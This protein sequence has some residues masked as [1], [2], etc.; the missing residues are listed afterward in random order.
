[1]KRTIE[2]LCLAILS[3]MPVQVTEQAKPTVAIIGTG[4]MG[5]SLGPKIAERGYP[6]VYGSREPARESVRALVRQTGENVSVASQRDAAARAQIVIL[7]VPWPPMEEV[8]QSLGDLSGKIIVDVSYPVRRGPDGY[9]EQSVEPSAGELI[10]GWNPRA[11][12]V[13]VGMPSSY[14]V[15]DPMTLGTT[16]TVPIAANDREAKETIATLIANIGLDPWD[17]GPL[18]F[19][20]S[21]ESFGLL[22]WVPLQQGRKEG[23]EIKFIRS[24]YWPCVWDVPKEF[25]PTADQGNLANFPGGQPPRP[26]DSYKSR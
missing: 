26:C 21:I 18:R 7:A 2:L 15:D 1:V 20:R 3:A 14:I 9:M 6:V 22:F 11:K 24:S 23:I 16:P 19:S 5:N 13:K 25:G 17:A 12:V 4:D 8:A 10:Q